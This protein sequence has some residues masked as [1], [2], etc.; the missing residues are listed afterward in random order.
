[1]KYIVEMQTDVGIKKQKNQDSMCVKQACTNK[2]D[3]VFAVMCDGMGGLEKG[4]LA[5]ATIIR[6]FAKWFDDELPYLLAKKDP[7]SEIKYRCQQLIKQQN[8]IIGEYGRTKHIQLGSTITA[9]LILEDGSF[10]ICHVGDSRAY[11]I[12]DK[13]IDILTT[14][15]TVVANEVRLGRLTEKQAETDP[16]RN[17]LLQCIGASRVVEPD[18]IEGKIQCDECYLLCCD[19]FRR[20]ISKEEIHQSLN[21][22]SNMNKNEMRHHITQLIELNKNRGEI[23]NISAILIRIE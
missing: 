11:R 20:M 14:D 8:Q 15:Q 12:S 2:G 21:P 18:F 6:Q 19:G 10:L 5:S 17:V 22:T 7:L 3:I 16:R 13:H 23:D 9:L 4:E 1:M